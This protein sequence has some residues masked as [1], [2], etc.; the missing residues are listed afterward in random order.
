VTSLP[1]QR[2]QYRDLDSPDPTATLDGDTGH[3]ES[4][5]DMERFVIPM[6]Q[7]DRSSTRGWG[8]VEGL[9]VTAVRGQRGVTLAPGVGVDSAGQLT[10]VAVGGAVI[11]DPNADPTDPRNVRTVIVP[12]TGITLSTNGLPA[13]DFFL[14]LTSR[15]VMAGP[16]TAPALLHA[17]WLRLQKPGEVS[18]EGTR[19]IAA[20]V[21]LDASGNV[22]ALTT[23]GRVLSGL[24]TGGLELRGAVTRTS[25]GLSVDHVPVAELAVRGNGALELAA[26]PTAAGAPGLVAFSLAAATGNLALVPGGGNVGIGLGTGTAP[27]RPLHV[28][29]K[30]VHS[31]GVEGGFS[32]ADR[33]ASVADQRA[34]LAN[35]PTRGERWSWYAKDGKARLWSGSDRLTVDLTSPGGGLEVSRRMRVRKGGD[36]PSAGIWFTHEAD[37]GFVGLRTSDE[38]GFFGVG[39]AAQWG[40][41]MNVND[42]TVTIAKQLDV[43]GR[44]CAQ[45]FCNLSDGRLKTDVRALDR[46]L[47]QLDGVRGVAFRWD[48]ALL[49]TGGGAGIGVIAQE[50]AEVFP[51][52]VTSM[53]AGDGEPTDREPGGRLAVDYSGLVAVLIE[54]VKEL[55]AEN[56]D[57]R[58]RLAGLESR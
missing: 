42:G 54:A 12:N 21:S 17:P 39:P 26:L 28:E 22:T 14:T 35:A 25:D 27:A 49:S 40:L 38:I 36:D 5:T 10:V 52:L 15:E 58:A 9:R 46:P 11:V 34:A 45:T 48:P 32:F 20:T 56:R 47:E 29:G 50:V 33:N 8:V 6:G 2:V 44:S 3:A 24:R 57:I 55:A 41:T 18:P 13:G 1:L 31:G 43:M 16:A 51:E 4:R 30:E 19:I 53:A 23:A 37:R 7:V